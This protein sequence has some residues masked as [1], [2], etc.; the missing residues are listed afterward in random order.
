MDIES[1]FEAQLR[2]AQK[3]A[4]F[5]A[6]AGAVSIFGSLLSLA[7][8]EPG[9]GYAFSFALSALAAS[10]LEGWVALVP[11]LFVSG[12]AIFLALMLAKMK[13]AAVFLAPIAIAVDTALLLFFPLLDYGIYQ[14]SSGVPVAWYLAIGVHAILLVFLALFLSAYAKLFRLNKER[15]SYEQH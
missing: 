8:P 4:L 11:S 5:L 14:G 15:T 1:S 3:A 12:A 7:L 9:Y 6:Y 2:R 13:K 10:Y